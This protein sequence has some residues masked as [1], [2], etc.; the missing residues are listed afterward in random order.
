MSSL[1]NLPYGEILDYWYEKHLGK[2]YRYK[3]LITKTLEVLAFKWNS[4]NPKRPENPP[5]LNKQ[6]QLAPLKTTKL[7]LIIPIYIK[8]EIDIQHLKRLTNS[9]HNLD[10]SPDLIIFV[11]DASPSTFDIN[12]PSNKIKISSNKGPAYARNQGISYAL[13]QKMDIIAFTDLDCILSSNWTKTILDSFKN[14]N[15]QAMLSGSTLSFGNTWFDQYHNLNGTLNGR[16]F[17]NS[18]ELLYGPTCNLAIRSEVFE[19]ISF[20]EKFP[21]AAGEDIEFCYQ[22]IL[23]GFR[24]RH[25]QE[26]IIRHNFNY[27]ESLVKNLIAFVRLFA[28]Y[29]K[30]EKVLLENIPNYYSLF[31]NTEEITFT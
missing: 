23:Q 18:R 3:F 13:K 20:N 21:S 14:Q 9:I 1:S 30:G 29:G 5:L 16:K 10:H 22:S 2:S 27:T 6:I 7:C 28:K 24:I 8:S 11:D 26:M 12:I 4:G 15:S 19:R 31:D 17:K 25:E